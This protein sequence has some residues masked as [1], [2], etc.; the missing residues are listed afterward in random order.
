MSGSTLQVLGGVL[1]AVLLLGLLVLGLADEV[2]AWVTVLRAVWSALW[3]WIAGKP[4][5]EQV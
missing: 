4:P 1:I 2:R 3:R 5:G